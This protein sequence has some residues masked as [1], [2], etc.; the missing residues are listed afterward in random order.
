V[1]IAVCPG[2]FDQITNGHLDIYERAAKIVD[3]LIVAVFHNPNK[4]PVFTV[5]ERLEML[6]LSTKHIHNVKVDYFSGLLNE[7]VKQQNSKIIIRGLRALS[8]FESEFQRALLIKQIDPVIETVFMMTSSE[9]SFVSSSGI[10]ELAKFDGKITGLVP[11]C[12]E[13]KIKTRLY[14]L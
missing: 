3:V 13:D 8:D 7:Y 9:Y 4:T 1:R 10:K 14:Q 11:S 6:A 2:S 12:I 5:E